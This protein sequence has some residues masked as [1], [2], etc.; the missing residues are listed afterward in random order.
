MV[1]AVNHAIQ[2]RNM[3]NPR[4][5]NFRGFLVFRDMRI[6]LPQ[7]LHALIVAQIEIYRAV[8]EIIIGQT[9]VISTKLRDPA[10]A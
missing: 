2:Q 3:R 4:S 6:I 7:K 5:G 9:P 10:I 1:N 8:F